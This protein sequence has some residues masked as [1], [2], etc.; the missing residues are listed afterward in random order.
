MW[1]WVVSNWIPLVS[2]ST[3]SALVGHA[4]STFPPQNNPYVNW[5]LGIIQFAIGQRNAG[6]NTL[7]GLSST[8]T[9]SPVIR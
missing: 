6:K 1:R 4:V 3:F 8:V 5:F 9:G 2:G 7:Q